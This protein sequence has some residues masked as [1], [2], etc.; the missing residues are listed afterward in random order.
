[1]SVSEISSSCKG[2]RLGG[3]TLHSSPRTST[4]TSSFVKLKDGTFIDDIIFGCTNEA[5]NHEFGKMMS[6]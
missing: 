6:M 4:G 5:L 3:W 1:M 2:S